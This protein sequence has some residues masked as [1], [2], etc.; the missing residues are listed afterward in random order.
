M[1]GGPADPGNPRDYW[2]GRSTA[3]RA[4]AASGKPADE[5]F[6]RA[7]IEA[8][9]IRRGDA[10][11]D[12]AAGTGDPSVTIACHLDGTGSV[13][14]LDM[15][16]DMLTA[17]RARAEALALRTIRLAVG[18]MAV[19]PF[20]DAAFDAVTCRNGLMFPADRLACV[21]EARR[22]LKRGRRA[23]WLAWATVEENPTFLMVNAALRRYFAEDIPLR[24]VRH[25]LG[26]AGALAALLEAAG[27]VD[28]AERCIAYERVVPAGDAYFRRAVERTVPHR[29]GALTSKEWRE[30]L[31]ILEAECAA[32]RVGGVFHIPVVARLGTGTAPG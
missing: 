15:T 3:W 5:T 27:F 25:A 23:A 7:L 21:R 28:V 16:V 10:V 19:L 13:T 14:A 8:A 11:L 2:K 20:A 12:L 31:G 22:V 6:D 26:E 24:M 30:L 9:A 17:A 4:G 1:S 29:I 18:D 32:L